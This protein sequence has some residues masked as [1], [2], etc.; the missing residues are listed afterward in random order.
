MLEAARAAGLN[1]S[2]L[3]SPKTFLRAVS[4][5]RLEAVKVAGRW[6]TSPAAIRRYVDQLQRDGDG[7]CA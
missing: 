7:A 1:G 6:L 3:P 5:R 2:A 4:A